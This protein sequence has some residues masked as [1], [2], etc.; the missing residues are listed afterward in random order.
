VR[1]LTRIVIQGFTF[2]KPQ[3][4]NYH[5]SLPVSWDAVPTV[6]AAAWDAHGDMFDGELAKAPEPP[7][8]FAGSPAEAEAN[9]AC[10]AGS[11]EDLLPDWDQREHLL[12]CRVRVRV[13]SQVQHMNIGT[14]LTQ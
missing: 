4:H 7:R 11:P 6:L 8:L 5:T 10:E 13:E 1:H 2:S 14:S 3:P 9:L 12:Q